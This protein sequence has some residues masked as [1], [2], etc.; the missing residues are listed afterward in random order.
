MIRSGRIHLPGGQVEACAIKKLP[1]D[2]TIPMLAA[3]VHSE[4][5]ALHMARELPHMVHG[6]AAFTSPEEGGLM[7]IITRWVTV[8]DLCMCS[9][10]LTAQLL[11]PC[12]KLTRLCC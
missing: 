10:A 2:E 5:T 1:Y 7:Y 6:L 11:D 3:D 12:S 9:N 4:L 8:P